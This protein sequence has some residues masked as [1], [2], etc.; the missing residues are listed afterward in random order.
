MTRWYVASTR[1]HQEARAI[2]HLG[3]QGYRTW[4][5]RYRRTRRHARRFDTVL[6]PLFPGYVFVA[7]G[8][9]TRSWRPVSGTFGVRQLISFGGAPA[10][11]PGGFIDEL[12][13][14]SDAE[15]LV[16][17]S[18]SSFSPGM[19]VRVVSGPFAD[20]VGR[21]IA[22]DD[23]RRVSLLLEVLGGGATTFLPVEAVAPLA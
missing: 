1:P 7:L 14:R 5:P 13:A 22:L 12:R 8:P 19:S 16:H 9:E 2:E 10:P 6:A 4:F 23:R 21:L 15:G 17:A 11:L 20:C 3:R 18:Q